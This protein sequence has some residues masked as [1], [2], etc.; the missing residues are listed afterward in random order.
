MGYDALWLPYDW[1]GR[2]RAPVDVPRFP[3]DYVD[4]VVFLFPSEDAAREGR[5]VGGTGFLAAIPFGNTGLAHW[6]VITNRHVIDHG[7]RT[8]RV[9]TDDGRSVPVTIPE[10]SWHAHSRG[11]DIAAAYFPQGAF[12]NANG[13][14]TKTF[15]TERRLGKWELGVGDDLMV[16]S[17]HVGYQGKVQ[18]R[19]VLHSGMISLSPPED[20]YNPETQQD[21]PSFLIEARSWGGFSGSPVLGYRA[22]LQPRLGAVNRRQNIET[23]RIFVVGM[24]WGHLPRWEPIHGA[25]GKQTGDYVRV[26]TGMSAVVPAWEIEEV[27]DLEVFVRER[28]QYEKM[29]D[30]AFVTPEVQAAPDVA[31][32]DDL[33]GPLTAGAFNEALRRA[34]RIRPEFDN[35][36]T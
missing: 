17:R 29:W 12:A 27:L 5:Q 13:L 35:P 9:N 26:N 33:E 16:I 34:T 8:V 2:H 3:D 22:P 1:H 6:Y 10:P 28:E 7:H 19:P 30:E 18:N 4:A 11:Y 21:E 36:F 20:V 31:N 14:L 23:A 32:D 15:I 24:I 25:T